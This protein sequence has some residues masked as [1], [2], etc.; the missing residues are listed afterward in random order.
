MKKI[1]AAIALT[2]L[3]ASSFAQGSSPTPQSASDAQ[4]EKAA[5]V[6]EAKQSQPT[7]KAGK[8]AAKADA[9]AQTGK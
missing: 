7:K 1:V 3:T 6:R 8:S 5:V 2:I 4:K 9:S